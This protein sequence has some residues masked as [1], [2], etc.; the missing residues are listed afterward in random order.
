MRKTTKFSV[1]NKD[2]HLQV[3]KIRWGDNLHTER[4]RKAAAGRA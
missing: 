1:C 4:E 3:K 2:I